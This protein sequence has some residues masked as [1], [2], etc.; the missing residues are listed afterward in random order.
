MQRGI[1]GA[2]EAITHVDGMGEGSGDDAW[3]YA[4][5]DLHHKAPPVPLTLRDVACPIE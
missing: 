2:G 3:V 5:H 1:K 4:S